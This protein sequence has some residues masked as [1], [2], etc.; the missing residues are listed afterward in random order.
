MDFGLRLLKPFVVVQVLLIKG[1][2]HAIF[3]NDNHSDCYHI[4][5]KE[6]NDFLDGKYSSKV[7][8]FMDKPFTEG[9]KNG[10]YFS[11][12]KNKLDK[13]MDNIQRLF[14]MRFKKND[15]FYK[16][17]DV[18]FQQSELSSDKLGSTELSSINDNV[19]IY[20]VE[21]FTVDD[22]IEV[23]KFIDK[24]RTVTKGM[25]YSMVFDELD[26]GEFLSV[27]A[28]RAAIKMSKEI[29]YKEILDDLE[30]IFPAGHK[31]GDYVK[32]VI[33]NRL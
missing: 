28:T 23:N 3:D 6:L 26:N 7:N 10:F 15:I 4:T 9:G 29:A 27:S 14:G 5:H 1:K 13:K 30:I 12:S 24:D 2:Y 33:K 19:K 21:D 17:M 31:M 20:T 32:K 22:F 18:S 25:G 11:L 16:I 8:L